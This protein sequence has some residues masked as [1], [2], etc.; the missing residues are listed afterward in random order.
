MYAKVY[1]LKSHSGAAGAI[2]SLA[3]RKKEMDIAWEDIP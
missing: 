3:E 2:E 1:Q